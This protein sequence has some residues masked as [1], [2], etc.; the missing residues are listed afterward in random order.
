MKNPSFELSFHMCEVI[1]RWVGMLKVAHAQGHT[2]EKVGCK[3]G[4]QIFSAFSV[5][6]TGTD[7]RGPFRRSR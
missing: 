7:N 6:L 5:P 4:S 1:P 3:C 2:G